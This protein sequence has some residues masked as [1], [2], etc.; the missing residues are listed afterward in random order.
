MV[1][2]ANATKK[3]KSY[4]DASKSYPDCNADYGD[5]GDEWEDKDWNMVRLFWRFDICFGG[6][7]IEFGMFFVFFKLALF[8]IR[9]ANSSSNQC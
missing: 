8:W 5:Y 7:F 1:Q 3:T 2:S 4:P 6:D 9:G